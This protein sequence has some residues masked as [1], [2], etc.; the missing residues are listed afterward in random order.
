MFKF[1]FIKVLVALALALSCLPFVNAMDR[2]LVSVSPSKTFNSSEVIIKDLDH[3]MAYITGESRYQETLDEHIQKAIDNSRKALE[4][5]FTVRLTK[6]VGA[7]VILQDKADILFTEWVAGSNDALTRNIFVWDHPD[8]ELVFF[9]SSRDSVASKEWLEKFLGNTVASSESPL[10]IESVK[11]QV[12][13]SV[14]DLGV[15]G[16]GWVE[17]LV[18]PAR[19]TRG[20]EFRVATIFD[21]VNA[22]IVFEI[23]KRLFTAFSVN[24]V[25]SIPERFPPL[26]DRLA[27]LRKVDIIRKLNGNEERDRVLLGELIRRGLND[28]EFNLLMFLVEFD[29]MLPDKAKARQVISLISEIIAA[30]KMK[31]FEKKIRNSFV[32]FEAMAEAGTPM[33]QALVQAILRDTDVDF[34]DEVIRLMNLGFI[35][36]EGLTYLERHGDTPKVVQFL[37]NLQVPAEIEESKKTAIRVIES[38]VS[39]SRVRR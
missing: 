8:F 32:V 29:S 10:G 23:G 34:S 30:G 2:I 9:K 22:Y 11:L 7:K 3:A 24:S 25:S 38:R 16:L 17:Y 4:G 39:K 28:K 31:A 35:H 19:I 33:L 26:K 13:D 37:V 18:R 15:G 20:Y 21:E 14:P 12:A 36:R 6:L 27:G 1:S 5:L